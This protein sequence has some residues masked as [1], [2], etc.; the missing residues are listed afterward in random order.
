VRVGISGPV[1]LIAEVTPAAVRELEL[2]E[3]SEVWASIKATD[4]TVF[5]S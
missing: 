4:V 5:P 2:D 3:G 1:P